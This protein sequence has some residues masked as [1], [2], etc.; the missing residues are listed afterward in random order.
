[1]RR[2]AILVKI[3]EV[4]VSQTKTFT[5]VI[6]DATLSDKF[7]AEVVVRKRVAVRASRDRNQIELADVFITPI[8]GQHAYY[9]SKGSW[10]KTPA[11]FNVATKE[12]SGSHNHFVVNDFNGRGLY[13][14]RDS[15]RGEEHRRQCSIW[16]LGQPFASRVMEALKEF[17]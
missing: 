11:T 1:M 16:D 14:V 2:H 15:R 12:K 6:T 7:S 10:A 5:C 17:S 4:D 9:E 8:S 13:I 3:R